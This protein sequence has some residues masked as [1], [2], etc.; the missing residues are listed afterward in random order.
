M[1]GIQDVQP[2]GIN[3]PNMTGMVVPAATIS[4]V[5]QLA[6]AYRQGFITTSDIL[7]APARRKKLDAEAMLASE[8]VDPLAIEARQEATRLAGETARGARETALTKDF[9][10]AYLKYNL[11]LKKADG[12]PDYS[13]M[14]EVGQKY[15]DMERTLAYAKAGMT[16]TPTPRIDEKTGRTYSVMLNAYGEDVTDSPGQKNAALEHYR[17][18]FRK[19]SSFLIQNDN[20]PDIPEDGTA[21]I[22]RVSPKDA[23][24]GPDP[25]PVPAAAVTPVQRL[26]AA[27]VPPS[28]AVV[29]Q[30]TAGITPVVGVA[31]G[32][33][34]GLPSAG[35]V[36]TGGTPQVFAAQPAAPKVVIQP[37]ATGQSVTVEPAAAPVAEAAKPE[38]YVP[39][40]GV[41]SGMGDYKPDAAIK[42]ARAT[43]LYKNWSEKSG[44][45]AGFRTLVKNYQSLPKGSVTT[46]N[47]LALANSAM[48][49]AAMGSSG[50]SPRG[51]GQELKRIEESI[52]IIERILDLPDI[53]LQRDKFPEGVRERL[54]QVTEQKARE[55]ESLA[56]DVIKTT[57]AQLKQ[58]GYDPM[59]YLFDAE[60]QLLGQPARAAGGGAGRTIT[61]PSGRRVVVSQ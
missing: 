53:V 23:A 11:P 7:D 45:I 25:A 26:A 60:K 50:G 61:L 55:I 18:L 48:Q 14:A 34:Q 35:A 13:G 5:E 49:I 31:G 38:V 51:M 36:W 43:E 47:D 10:G 20:E 37:T 2:K 32:T 46:Q 19:A 9:V 54:I 22:I 59:E 15:G 6:N 42:D 56:G 39:G 29:Q 44:S 41:L 28:P 57:G 21:P 12:T 1:A 33:I 52:P 58:R 27:P 24:P 30:A 8:Q 16:G 3:I 17:K 40:T 4:A